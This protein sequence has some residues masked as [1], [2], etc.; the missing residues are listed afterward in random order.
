M[1]FEMIPEFFGQLAGFS[2][3]AIAGPAAI[4]FLGFLEYP[5]QITG[6]FLGIFVLTSYCDSKAKLKRKRA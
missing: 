6:A 4:T 5:A 3:N 2:L 1:N